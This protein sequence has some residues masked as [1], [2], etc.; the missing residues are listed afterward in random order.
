MSIGRKISELQG[1][2][3]QFTNDSTTIAINLE[4]YGINRRWVENMTPL[5]YRDISS[6]FVV[7]REDGRGYGEVSTIWASDSQFGALDA[8]AYCVYSTDESIIL[9]SVPLDAPYDSDPA[10]SLTCAGCGV[11]LEESKAIDVNGS[12][13]CKACATAWTITGEGHDQRMVAADGQSAPVALNIDVCQCC[14]HGGPVTA[15]YVSRELAR[16]NKLHKRNLDRLVWVCATCWAGG[17]VVDRDKYGWT[18]LTSFGRSMLS[19]TINCQLDKI[20]QA[21]WALK[22]AEAASQK[23]VK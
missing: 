1:E 17:E 15:V 19:V 11:E 5:N 2:N 21:R 3:V 7:M 4:E 6:M 13:H 14:G 16:A 22:Q 23:A 9:G 10:P 18:A 12:N 20:K 8:Y